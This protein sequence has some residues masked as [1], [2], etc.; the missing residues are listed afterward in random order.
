MDFGVLVHF[1]LLLCSPIH[2]RLSNGLA[3][4][5][6]CEISLALYIF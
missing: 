1:F 3:K 2:G 5:C 4:V 6:E